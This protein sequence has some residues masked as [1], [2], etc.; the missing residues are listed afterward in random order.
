MLVDL[1]RKL[2][3]FKRWCPK[4]YNGEEMMRMKYEISWKSTQLLYNF[5]NVSV[6]YRLITGSMIAAHTEQLAW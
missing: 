4:P 2:T 3:V 6:N 1:I 5:Y